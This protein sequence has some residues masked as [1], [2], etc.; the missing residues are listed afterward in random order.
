MKN[1]LSRKPTPEPK[2][3]FIKKKQVVVKNIVRELTT[4]K[5]VSVNLYTENYINE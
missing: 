2:R 5:R 1:E 4:P 3:K